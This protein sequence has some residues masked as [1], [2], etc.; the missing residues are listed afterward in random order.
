MARKI[1]IY[2]SEEVKKMSPGSKFPSTSADGEGAL[3]VANTD[4]DLKSEA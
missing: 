3:L 2:S 4:S 1:F